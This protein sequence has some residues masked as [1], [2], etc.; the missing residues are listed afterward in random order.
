VSV[1]RFVLR[2]ERLS[3]QQGAVNK[4]LQQLRAWNTAGGT[5]LFGNDLGAVESDPT[6]EYTLMQ[7]AGMTFP[8]ILAALTTTPAARMGDAARLG[9]IASGLLADIT[10]VEGNLRPASRTS[11]GCA[12]PFGKE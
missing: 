3:T 9:K 8:Q 11:Q 4:A 10:V 1:W 2:H 5:A 7:R 6:E 12:T